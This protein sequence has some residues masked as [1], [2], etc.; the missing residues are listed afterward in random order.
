MS[1][2][3]RCLDL[4]PEY[5]EAYY[6]AEV[7]T[8]LPIEFEELVELKNYLIELF[9]TFGFSADFELTVDG[10]FL[11]IKLT[12]FQVSQLQILTFFIID[13]ILCHILSAF[14]QV[15]INVIPYKKLEFPKTS[16]ALHNPTIDQIDPI[17]KALMNT[18][19]ELAF[20]IIFGLNDQNLIIYIL[21]E[22]DYPLP[23]N[24]VY[25][26]PHPYLPIDFGSDSD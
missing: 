2:F 15:D 5:W 14:H 11:K 17:F 10:T 9:K 16:L 20:R 7:P 3:C 18:I 19:N 1:Y 8:P 24:F 26:L 12:Y 6:P 22:G 13:Q 4:Y 25:P 23:S 21:F